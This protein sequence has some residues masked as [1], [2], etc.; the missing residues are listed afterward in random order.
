VST[1]SRATLKLCTW[2]T[3]CDTAIFNSIQ[4]IQWV[5]E[6]FST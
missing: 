3:W 2:T 1:Q 4:Q 5:N 6:I